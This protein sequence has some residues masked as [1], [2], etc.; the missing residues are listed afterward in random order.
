MKFNQ[1]VCY[2]A[3]QIVS[4]IMC[5]YQSLANVIKNAHT[6]THAYAGIYTG[7]SCEEQNV[8]KKIYKKWKR[9]NDLS[10]IVR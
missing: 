2:K 9:E 3:L 1:C 4:S 7:N 6:Q 8:P 10:C 5:S